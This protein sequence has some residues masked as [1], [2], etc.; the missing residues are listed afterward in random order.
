MLTGAGDVIAAFVGGQLRGVA[1]PRDV[2]GDTLIFLTV[3]SN[4]AANETVR[5]EVW[6]EDKCRRYPS[7]LERF[8][9]SADAIIGTPSAPVSLT[10]VMSLPESVGEF[11]LN[12]GW[13]WFSTNVASGDMSIVNVLSTLAPSAGDIIKSKTAFA[14]FD[15]GT[16]SGWVGSLTTLD[17]TS[18]YMIRL[19]E[20]GTVLQEGSLADP[21]LTDIP[22]SAGW[23]WIAYA[24]SAANSAT[25]ALNDLDVQG[26]LNGGEVIKGQSTFAQWDAGWAGSLDTMGP[27]QGYRLFLHS[28]P[29]PGSFNYPANPGLVAGVAG[30]APRGGADSEGYAI[31][32]T[33]VFDANRYQSNMTVIAAIQTDGVD[34]R[35]DNDMIG[36]FVGDECRGTGH[37][38]YVDGIDRY[39]AFLMIHGDNGDGE[40]V[41]FRAFDAASKLV[42]DVEGTMT[43]EMDAMHGTL[44]E[45][46]V[47]VTGS[48][49][50]GVPSAFRLAQNHPNPFNPQTTLRFDLPRASHVVLTIYNVRG[51]E[52]RKLV[53]RNYGP[54]SYDV[55]WDGT[56]TRSD[57]A[58]SGVYFYK[59]NAGTF[60]DVKKMVLLK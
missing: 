31:S 4:R 46:V 44:S 13:N 14:S 45:P 19:T 21:S 26:F 42:Y 11:A 29:L 60:S 30:A 40:T 32:P 55:I 36:A 53:D 37:V 20:A 56:T 15:P 24:G 52:V 17:N 34:R 38:V 3:F 57:A 16:P 6:D 50:N 9:F 58:A 41:A 59:L 7:T 1:G 51:Q 18:G 28:G 33:W 27:G 49:Q 10:A 5:F 43:F 47:L 23:N 8:P 39:L 48:V 12:A 22:V 54:G 35:S 25:A 2:Q